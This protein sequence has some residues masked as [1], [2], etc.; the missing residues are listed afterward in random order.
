M[1]PKNQQQ[2]LTVMEENWSKKNI[3]TTLKECKVCDGKILKGESSTCNGE[4]NRGF[5]LCTFWTICS[6]FF[7]KS[8]L[9][10]LN[11]YRNN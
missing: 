11:Q 1:A 9:I 2:S 4:E 7:I 8:N 10:N 3:I 5:K 6:N